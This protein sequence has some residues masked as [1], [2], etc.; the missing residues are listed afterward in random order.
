MTPAERKKFLDNLPPG[1]LEE[2]WNELVAGAE[3]GRKIEAMTDVE[4]AEACTQTAG[5]LAMTDAM[6][7][8]LNEVAGRLRRAGQ[9]PY[10]QCSWCQN[11]GFHEHKNGDWTCAERVTK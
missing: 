3:R 4:V 2:F 9:G 10:R 6:Y 7:D 5:A 1:R 11:E 8:L